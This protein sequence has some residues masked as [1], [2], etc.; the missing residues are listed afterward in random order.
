MTDPNFSAAAWTLDELAA[1]ANQALA[2]S[3]PADARDSRLSGQL[4]ARNI[5]RLQTEGAI[6]PPRKLGREAYYGDGHL[7]QLLEARDL[8]S[9][10]VAASAIPAVREAQTTLLSS[11]SLAPSASPDR[12]LKAGPPSTA[13]AL[14]FLGAS[15][16]AAAAPERAFFGAAPAARVAARVV[17]E[18]EPLAGLRVSASPAPGAAPLTPSDLAKIIEA[19]QTAWNA[20]IDAPKS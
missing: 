9:K 18:C 10:G 5:R 7:R 16:K 13:Q 12:P 2:A 8:M 3:E 11:A 6:D 20:A 4:T 17:F 14:A 19:V 15:P 1:K